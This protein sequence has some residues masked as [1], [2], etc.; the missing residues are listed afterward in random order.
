MILLAPPAPVK[1]QTTSARTEASETAARCPLDQ[2]GDERLCIRIREELAAC[3][4]LHLRRVRVSALDGNVVL[5]GR[6][7]TYYLKQVAQARVLA[8]LGVKSLANELQV[9]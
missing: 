6:V 9:A 4:Q 1:W 3:G 7:P 5:G 8:M 2:N